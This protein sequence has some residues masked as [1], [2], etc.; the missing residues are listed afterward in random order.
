MDSF[1]K[2]DRLRAKSR[3]LR[4]LS[5]P[6]STQEERHLALESLDAMKRQRAD[7]AYRNDDNGMNFMPDQSRPSV[8][9]DMNRRVTNKYGHEVYA[10]GYQEF[11]DVKYRNTPV[12]SVLPGMFP[13]SQGFGL[14]QV[15]V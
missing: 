5:D 13:A 11:S 8:E 2:V 10:P 12:S 7:Y 1:N 15:N 14:K 4:T 6:Q 3:E 9:D